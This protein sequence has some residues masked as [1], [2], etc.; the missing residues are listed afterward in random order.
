M[1][2]AERSM[3]PITKDDLTNLRKI[4]LKEHEDFFRRNPHL[5]RNYYDSLIG[6]F[7]CQGAACHY[8]DLITGVKDWDIGYF[9]VKNA[10][11]YFPY[12]KRKRIEDGY[13]DKPID[14]LRRAIS[15]DIFDSCAGQPELTVMK[16]ML[17]RN[18]DTKKK[19]LKKA[20]IGLHPDA[21]FAKVLWK[22]A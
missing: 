13:R 14:F 21:V 18:T 6:I 17:E 1:K 4:A 9:Y 12:R 10:E 2:K 16:Y 8:L 19:L 20:I 15:R 5:K 3:A 22:G 11:I 7:L